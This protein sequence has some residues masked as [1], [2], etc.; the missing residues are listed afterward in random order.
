M[1]NQSMEALAGTSKDVGGMYS[2]S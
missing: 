1:W 2:S